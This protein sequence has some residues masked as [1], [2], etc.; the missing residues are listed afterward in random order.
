MQRLSP[1]YYP[2]VNEA[3]PL[4]Q[5]EGKETTPHSLRFKDQAGREGIFQ[6]LHSK[7]VNTGCEEKLKEI[8]PRW[9][10]LH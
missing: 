5:T 4:K 9:F 10:V 1:N 7:K 3:Q 8:P 6:G 2:G